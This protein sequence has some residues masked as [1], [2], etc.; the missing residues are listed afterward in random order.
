MIHTDNDI[1]SSLYKIRYFENVA[2]K[3]LAPLAALVKQRSYKKGEL[4]FSADQ[5]CRNL[6][7][8][9]SGEI[10]IFMVSEMGREQII[11]FIKPFV[12]FGEE[13]LFGENRYEACAAALCKTVL[14]DIGKKDLED[15]ILVR[16]QVGIAMLACFGERL[17][18]LMK[19]VGDLA[20]K[21]VQCRLVCRLVQMAHEQGKKT[22]DGILID[23]L[24]REE[25]ASYIGTVRES[26]SRCLTRLQDARLIKLGRKKIIVNDMDGLKD[27]SEFSQ[28]RMPIHADHRP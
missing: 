17:K 18:K 19:M 2:E 21:D 15:F 24:T 13:I 6:H 20:L 11:H 26:L 23:G 25:L 22:K 7:I 1:L 5:K 12:F 16:P 8:L 4:I 3:D 27:L 9:S 28:S 14:Y 10:K